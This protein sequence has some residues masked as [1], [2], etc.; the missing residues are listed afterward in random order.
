MAEHRYVALLRGINVGG[1]NIIKM[2]DLKA[3]FE[4]MGFT[5]VKTYIASGNVL[6]TSKKSAPKLEKGLKERFGYEAP[7]VILSAQE[8]ERVV[9]EAP[10]G[11]GK[12]PDKYRY[13]VIF[14]KEPLT[15]REALE[16]VSVKEGVDEVEAGQHALYFRRLISKA[17]QSRL[18][19]LTQT[20]AYKNVTVRNWN[21]TT[22]LLKLVS[23]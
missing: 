21:T 23:P 16:Q 6:F 13:D 12:Q 10:K 17:S 4:E 9:D 22:R 19:K 7:V 3:C 20:P 8:L 18:N 1:K 5:E 2:A 14:V 11:F 15:T